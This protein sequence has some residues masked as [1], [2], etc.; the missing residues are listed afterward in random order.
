M[1]VVRWVAGWVM[2]GIRGGVRRA[3]CGGQFARERAEGSERQE[4]GQGANW[5]WWIGVKTG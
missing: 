2:G 4:V 3:G 5:A 1:Q